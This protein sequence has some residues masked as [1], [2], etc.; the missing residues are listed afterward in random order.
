M[1]VLAINSGSSSLKFKLVTFVECHVLIQENPGSQGTW[2]ERDV[3][4][5]IASNTILTKNKI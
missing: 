2:T 4:R 3:N 5:W 1:N